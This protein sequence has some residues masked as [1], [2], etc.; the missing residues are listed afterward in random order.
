MYI[1]K[2]IALGAVMFFVFSVIYLWAWGMLPSST[3]AIGVDAIKGIVTHNALYWTAGILMLAL[4][5][6]IIAIWP[7]KV[8]TP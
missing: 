1:V 4:G 7:V 6:V 5:C 3:K 2:G 8:V